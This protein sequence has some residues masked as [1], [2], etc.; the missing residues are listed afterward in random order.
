M[1]I[2]AK[3]KYEHDVVLV[4]VRNPALSIWVARGWVYQPG[5]YKPHRG[6]VLVPQFNHRPDPPSLST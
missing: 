1:G 6:Q 5:F 2:V 4:D 3:I